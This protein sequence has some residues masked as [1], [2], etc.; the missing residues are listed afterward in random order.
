MFMC[1][2]NRV[3]RHNHESRA[4]VRKRSLQKQAIN[5][6]LWKYGAKHTWML[7]VDMDELLQPFAQST[8]G[9]TLHQITKPLASPV[10]AVALTGVHVRGG[11]HG[12]TILFWY[13]MITLV[14]KVG[15]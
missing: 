4:Q 14:L 12:P 5:H 10:C 6:C 13:E 2:S 15:T 7:V 9:E 3:S 1:H 8:V 11:G